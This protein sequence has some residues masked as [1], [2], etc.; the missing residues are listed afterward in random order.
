MR[1]RLTGW[2]F[3]GDDGSGRD[4]RGTLLLERRG[5]GRWFSTEFGNEVAASYDHSLRELIIDEILEEGVGG[6]FVFLP[7]P[8]ECERVGLPIGYAGLPDGERSH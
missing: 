8:G 3:C 7:D 4:T 2:W 1:E 5:D 6:N